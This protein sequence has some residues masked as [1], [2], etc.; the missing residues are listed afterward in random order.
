MRRPAPSGDPSA[1]AVPLGAAPPS[2]KTEPPLF[3]DRYIHLFS[4]KGKNFAFNSVTLDIWELE[5]DEREFLE[6][7][8]ANGGTDKDP[9]EIGDFVEAGILVAELT[10]PG[11][12]IST[13]AETR[14]KRLNRTGPGKFSQ[15]RISLTERCNMACTYCFQQA[16]YPEQQPRMS[17]ETLESTMSWFIGQAGQS[18]VDVQYFGGEPLLEWPL[19]MQAHE[20]LSRASESGLISG[21]RQAITTNGTVL[22]KDRAQ[23]MIDND[24]DLIFSFDGPPEI[25]DSLR[26]FKNGRGTFDKA[27]NGFR[28]WKEL[29]G[30][31]QILMTATESNLPHLPRYVRWFVEES[32]MEPRLIAL[33]SPQPTKNGWETGGKELAD[34]VF[35]LWMYCE[36]KG[37]G[38]QGP[39]TYIPA[40][41]R[42][43]VPQ[44]DH[45]I[46]GGMLSGAE[47]AWPI[48]V[49]A[50]GRRSLCLVHH[51]DER[52]ETGA[53]EGLSKATTWHTGQADHL[54][55]DTCIASQ[56]C[57]GPCSVER[58]MWGDRLN[59]DRCGFMREMT[60]NVV[61]TGNQG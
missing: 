37:V 45:C 2:L 5:E 22:K 53:E 26:I 15:L 24:F 60:L 52:V 61:S 35:D 33:N 56:V 55:C 11:T 32:G 43:K 18:Y 57:G 46:D 1:G 3:L 12:A 58:L 6:E 4:R 31:P 39:G 17:A 27:A 25:N 41:L 44:S 54:D 36:D 50:D 59:Q 7:V 42:T 30:E 8:K 29:G 13:L 28:L 38:F 14:R 23:W 48:Y 16:L 34:V 10:P 40:H 20:M 19:I 51:N 47:N 49:S 9:S 21:F